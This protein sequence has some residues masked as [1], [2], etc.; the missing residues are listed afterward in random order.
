MVKHH[1]PIL[2]I[3][4]LATW[5]ANTVAK[6][7]Q[8]SDGW[9]TSY[10][11]AIAKSKETD[12]P[13]L[14][15]F[16]GSDWCSFCLKLKKEVFGTKTFNQWASESV[17][18]L[19][20]DFPQ[21]NPQT[22][23]LR[24]QNSQLQAKYR[25]PGF[26]TVLFIDSEG[27]V[28][29][30]SGYIRGGVDQWI[31]RAQQIVSQAPKRVKLAKIEPV[32]DYSKGLELATQRGVPLMLIVEKSS[33]KLNRRRIQDLLGQRQLRKIA[34]QF[35]VVHLVR[36]GKGA[37]DPSQIERVDSLLS[38]YKVRPHPIQIVVIDL[39]EDELL[40]STQNL[41]RPKQVAGQ[42]QMKL[43]K[44]NYEGQWLEDFEQ[45][46]LIAVSLNRPMLM[47]FTGSDWCAPCIKLDKE[48]FKQ[49]P[50]KDY[51]REHLV[52][53]KIDFPMNKSQDAEIRSQ[54]E[55]LAQRFNVR[56]FPTVK[57][58]T[59]TGQELGTMGY[60]GAALDVFLARLKK[61]ATSQSL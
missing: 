34:D 47:D 43:L 39:K 50:F 9:T 58:F 60:T 4:L 2:A 31:V 28:L 11:E 8:R 10:E 36:T 57:I 38:K 41:L 1:I 33:R 45:A 53:V 55:A 29:G 51:A 61:I 14:M 6:S 15:N 16:T 18:L 19:E 23:S 37:T 32:T 5:T 40:Y 21:N 48:I 25:V 46:K 3:L 26:P 44:I 52:L 54:N 13:I 42:I 20:V 7:T 24:R 49:K 12:R 22:D 35:A 17:V 30:R 27:E 56:G 59:A